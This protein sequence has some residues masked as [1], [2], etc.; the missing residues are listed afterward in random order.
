MI[1]ARSRRN[2]ASS[3]TSVRSRGRADVTLNSRAERGARARVQRNDA[4]GEQQRLVDVVGDQE[5]GLALCAPDALDLVLQLGARQRVE[6]RQR[7]VEQQDLGTSQA[8]ARPRRAGACRPKAPRACGPTA[9]PRPTISTYF[10]V[11]RAALRAA[12][13]RDDRVDGERDVARRRQPRHQ[14]IALEHHA[15]LGAGARDRR[16]EQHLARGR[17]R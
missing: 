10:S 1:A 17:A 16:L 4:V 7:L 6:R 14:R 15:A 5:D 9:W 12:V 13:L 8:R 11:A 3:F 2:S